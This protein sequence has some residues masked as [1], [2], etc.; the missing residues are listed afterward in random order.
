[1][2]GLVNLDPS[3]L[4]QM[5]KFHSFLWL[6]LLLL[7]TYFIL[8]LVFLPVTISSPATVP[9]EL[10]AGTLT[11]SILALE[12]P[13][14]ERAREKQSCRQGRGPGDMPGRR[15]GVESL[16]MSLQHPQGPPGDE[17]GLTAE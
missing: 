6:L 3:M 10:Q 12:G 7:Q 2:N 14:N 11:W 15:L 17:Q 16:L 9:P 1:M 13:R 4:L 5:A 8:A